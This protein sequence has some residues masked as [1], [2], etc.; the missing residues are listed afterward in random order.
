MVRKYVDVFLWFRDS[1][2][3]PWYHKGGARSILRSSPL[4]M[5]FDVTKAAAATPFLFSAPVLA[6]TEV[7]G[8]IDGSVNWSIK[9][10]FIRH[11][12]QILS[13]T[14][15]TANEVT[16][17]AYLAVLLGTFVPVT[18]LIVLYVQVCV[19]SFHHL[20]LNVFC[21]AMLQSE[22]RK[23]GARGA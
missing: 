14:L 12:L 4:S 2:C 20:S 7:N 1:I 8:D 17:P 15:A 10:L 5:K 11:V 6:S 3:K 13:S 9:C 21:F 23:S 19:P 18:F 16:G 22:A